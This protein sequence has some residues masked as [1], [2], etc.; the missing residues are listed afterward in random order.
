LARGEHAIVIGALALITLIAWLYLERM[1]M[2]EGDL[3]GIA[4]RLARPMP[5]PV[6][7]LWL[8]FMMWAVMMVAMMMPSASPMVLMYARIARGRGGSWASVASFAAGYVAVWTIFSAIATVGQI[9]LQR[10]AMLSSAARVS[11][12][13]GGVILIAAGIYQM[14]PLKKACLGQCRSPIA[15]FMTRWRERAIGAFAMGIEHGGMCLGCCWMLMAILFVAGVMNLAWVAAISVLVAIEKIAPRGP[16]I[17]RIAG[18]ALM[19][20]G[21]VV[22]AGVI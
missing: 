14:T 15:F 22:A 4:A 11:P 8:T 7:E 6:I 16:M 1:P 20:G 5:A 17:A 12:F 3:G 21:G 2:S 19:V 10:A 13:A 18:A 9:G